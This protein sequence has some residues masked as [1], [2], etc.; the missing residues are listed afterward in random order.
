[1]WRTSEM[2]SSAFCLGQWTL[3]IRVML[4]VEREQS[5]STLWCWLWWVH[6]LLWEVQTCVS[7][8]L[9]WLHTPSWVSSAAW[10][11]GEPCSHLQCCPAQTEVRAWSL[12]FSAH[13]LLGCL[14]R[15]N[16]E[17]SFFTWFVRISLTFFLPFF[18]SRPWPE[19]KDSFL[20]FFPFLAH[21][22]DL[23]DKCHVL[24]GMMEM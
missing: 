1:M 2:T 6:C 14:W 5:S 15:V 12:G 23:H 19:T 13:P 11:A 21:V 9:L 17:I 10:W 24:S 18:H 20:S 22:V 8:T 7:D 3:G 4:G 16:P